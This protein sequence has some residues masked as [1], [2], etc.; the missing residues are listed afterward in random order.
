MVRSKPIMVIHTFL[1]IWLLLKTAEVVR[2]E[3]QKG[4][5]RG[6]YEDWKRPGRG[7]VKAW[8]RLKRGPKEAWKKPGGGPEEA[9]RLR[10]RGPEKGSRRGMILA[11]KRPQKC[12][13][14]INCQ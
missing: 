7:L 4:P 3:A 11:R 10:R 12:F 6:S 14:L 13:Q 8:T 9:R 2:K 5:T 1:F